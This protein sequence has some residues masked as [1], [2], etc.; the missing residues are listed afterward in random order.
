MKNVLIVAPNWVGDLVLATATLRAIRRGLADGARLS[1]L[2]RANLLD[3]L[4]GCPWFD[5]V[6]AWPK[7][8]DGRR[9]GV[10]AMARQLR[11]H[12]FDTVVLMPNSF[13]SGV[14]AWLA[15]IPRRLGYARDG[16]SLF[17]TDRV[18]PV[19]GGRRFLPESMTTYYAR[20]AEAI[21][22][23]VDDP[24]LELFVTDADR[25][26]VDQLLGD[27]PADGPLVVLNPGG[28]FGTS[29]Y[30]PADRYGQL[31]DRLLSRF[32]GRVVIS[33]APS[34]SAVLGRVADAMERPAINLADSPIRL[35][36]VREL[37]RRADLLVTNDTGPRHFA[38]ALGTPVVTLFGSTDPAWTETHCEHERQVRLDLE[39][40]PCQQ[41]TCPLGHHNCMRMMTV[42]R[43]EEVAV[44][45]LTPDF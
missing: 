16:R 9:I 5:E 44:E 40:S 26:A 43:V 18:R 20:L 45:L 32:G 41:P 30:W 11:R 8:A 1:I 13:R 22:C 19:K 35:S 36:A 27:G 2:A 25:A 38:V 6:I 37:I 23:P 39:C 14:L 10:W 7:R 15:R 42:E 33:G 3:V 12:R 29:K 17:L 21:G 34:E 24:R 28:A 4:E 31:A